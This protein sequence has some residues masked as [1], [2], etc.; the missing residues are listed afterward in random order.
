M[1]DYMMTT[2]SNILIEENVEKNNK[3]SICK[4]KS[5]GI[6]V[7]KGD[8]VVVKSHHILKMLTGGKSEK[9]TKEPLILGKIKNA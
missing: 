4:S 8:T 1:M 7:K 6:F 2:N 5:D 9:Y 3:L